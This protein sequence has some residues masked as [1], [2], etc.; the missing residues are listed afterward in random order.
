M[1]KSFLAILYLSLFILLLA[2][3]NNESAS[4]EDSPDAAVTNF[5]QALQQ[6]NY[7]SA[8]EYYAENLDNMAQFRNQVEDIS[9]GIAKKL[10][11]KMADF[12]YTIQDTYIDSS[13]PNKAKVTVTIDAYDL[14]KSFEST[15]L[16]YIKT[17]I[18]MTFDGSKSDDIIKEADSTLS[19][20]IDESKKDFSSEVTISLTKD[21]DKW[22]VDKI[23][24]NKDLLNA[25]SGNIINTI[26]KLSD[27]LN[28]AS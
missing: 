8:K 12:S 15:V 19:K 6:Q 5:L 28:A 27:Q 22:K 23:S 20:D 21:N 2:G 10:F 18:E 7:A 11:E 14:G 13:D 26:E 16:E 3:C 17:D 24:E 9:P 25:L 4:K 1:K